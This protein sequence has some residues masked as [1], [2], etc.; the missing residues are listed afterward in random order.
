MGDDEH[1]FASGF[2][3]GQQLGVKDVA[4]VWVLI[5]GPFVED[6][7]WPVFEV[8]SEQ[9]KAFAL[10]LGE[11]GSGKAAIVD[12]YFVLQME[13]AQVLAGLFIDVGFLKAEEALEEIKIAKDG[14]K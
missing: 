5:G 9:R 7:K 2:Q 11:R 4:E 13:L 3:V 8:S 12:F 14:G 10:T 6:V 1:G